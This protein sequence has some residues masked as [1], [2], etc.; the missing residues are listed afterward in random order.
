MPSETS[1]NVALR[2]SVPHYKNSFLNAQSAHVGLKVDGFLSSDVCGISDEER[3]WRDAV[4]KYDFDEMSRL[5][6]RNPSLVNWRD[7][8]TGVS[9]FYLLLVLNIKL[10]PFFLFTLASQLVNLRVPECKFLSLA[11]LHF[12]A[13]V[14]DMSLVRLLAGTYKAAVDIR[15][16]VCHRFYP[17]T[18]SEVDN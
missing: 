14:N 17:G 7:Y 12:A 11:A 2:Q 8:I 1:E 13:Q 3:K 18:H 10:Y 6:S 5:L 15:N 9:V 16:H 4:L